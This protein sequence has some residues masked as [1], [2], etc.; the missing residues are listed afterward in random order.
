MIKISAETHDTLLWLNN[1]FGER[2]FTF[3]EVSDRISP[4]VFEKFKVDKFIISDDTFEL[5]NPGATEVP[6]GW[7]INWSVAGEVIKRRKYLCH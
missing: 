5:E 3:S 6:E 2:P 7:R 4:V 1:K